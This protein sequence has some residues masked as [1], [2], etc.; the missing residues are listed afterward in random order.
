MILYGTLRK[1][2]PNSHALPRIPNVWSGSVTTFCQLEY[3]LVGSVYGFLQSL[4]ILLS[5]LR[6]EPPTLFEL[7]FQVLRRFEILIPNLITNY[8]QLT[9]AF[10]V[11]R[12]RV[13]RF[14]SGGGPG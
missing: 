9:R 10:A 1:V 11:P 4:Q 6:F 5:P 12:F 7:P 3:L 14:Q 2:L 8:A 13:P